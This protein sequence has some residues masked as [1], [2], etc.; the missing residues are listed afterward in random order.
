MKQLISFEEVAELA[1]GGNENVRQEHISYAAICS[2]QRKFIKPVLGALYDAVAEGEYAAL[3]DEYIKP[4]LAGYVKYMALP[5]ISAQVGVAG[6]V[7]YD[8]AEFDKA[9][10]KAFA[11]VLSRI[12]NEADALAQVMIDHIEAHAE[13]YPE[14]SASDN[15]KN[16]VSMSGN[17]I[18]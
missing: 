11:R 10:D 18:L 9:G 6:V 1:F 17:I 13:Q 4:A 16:R 14:Y 7:Q 5:T 2:A 8:G 12:K 3:L 15:I